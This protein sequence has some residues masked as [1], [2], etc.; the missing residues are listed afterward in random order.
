MLKLC[1]KPKSTAPKKRNWKEIWIETYWCFLYLD[2][3]WNT[4]K[5]LNLIWQTARDMI[6]Q[7]ALF[8]KP[9]NWM[10]NRFQIKYFL[11][12]QFFRDMVFLLCVNLFRFCF[13]FVSFL[14]RLCCREGKITFALS[15][16]ILIL[17]NGAKAAKSTKKTLYPEKKRWCAVVF[18]SSF[19]SLLN[20]NSI[21]RE[22]FGGIARF[23][24]LLC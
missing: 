7:W 9:S 16:L 20:A 5:N 17:L 2:Y 3:K 21:G 12:S 4:A 8:S 19:S 22:P 13:V 23:Y 18:N 14:F 10:L 11:S 15:V 6:A 1:T 24:Y